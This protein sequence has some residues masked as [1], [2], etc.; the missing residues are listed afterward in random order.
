MLEQKLQRLAK[1]SEQELINMGF[2]DKL[3][4]KL[5]YSISNAKRRLGQCVEKRYINISRWLLE[6]GT[7]KEIK[8]TIIHEIL[9]T[10][11][12]TIG[13]GIVWQRYARLVN[14]YGVYNI[15]TTANIHN[16]M[17]N[18]N[19]SSDE[20]KAI[21]GYKYEI[22]CKKC[23]SVYYKRRIEQRVLKGYE[24]GYRK[25]NA[26]GGTCFKVVDLKTNNV[27]VDGIR[28]EL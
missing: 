3:N 18:N 10:F 25:H 12:D 21:L 28:K 14:N 6:I 11:D 7:D 26:C 15:K 20:E 9:H 5:Y 16:I 17:N 2:S 4:K 27:L 22:T 19:I 1:E 13:H 23:G 24:K 8:N